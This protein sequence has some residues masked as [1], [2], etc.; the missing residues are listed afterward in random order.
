MFTGLIE[1]VGTITEIR[2][3]DAGIE[4]RINCSYADLLPGESISVGGVCLTVL[5]KGGGWF[6]VAAMVMTMSRTSI[7]GWLPGDAVNLERAMKADSRFGGHIVQGHVDAVGTVA[8]VHRL[9]DTVLLTIAVPQDIVNA[10]VLH[11]SVALDGVSLT[12]NSL[13]SDKLQVALI[14]YTLRH[15]SLGNLREGSGVNVETDVIGKYVQ[16]LVVPYLNR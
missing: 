2:T 4:L 8:D 12:V 16:R 6:T 13:E 9:D 14:D 10:T 3:T 1:E 5:E 15:T 11:G 7:G